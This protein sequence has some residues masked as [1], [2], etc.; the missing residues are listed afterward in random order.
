M[1]N[2]AVKLI[3]CL[4]WMLGA[5]LLA[6]TLDRLPDPPAIKR[7]VVSLSAELDSPECAGP[8]PKYNPPVTVHVT[9]AARAV[10]RRLAVEHAHRPAAFSQETALVTEGADASPPLQFS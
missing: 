5:L 4:V 2:A 7:T 10:V 1:L 8:N 9:A 6:G 3:P